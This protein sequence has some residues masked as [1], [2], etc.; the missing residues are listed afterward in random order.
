MD[1]PNAQLRFAWLLVQLGFLLVPLQW[2]VIIP[3]T[4]LTIAR[5]G[6][7]CILAGAALGIVSTRSK[8]TSMSITPQI[9]LALHAFFL[10]FLALSS[11]WS[12]DPNGGL[13]IALRGL[14]YLTLTVVLFAFLKK[15]PT[16]HIVEKLTPAAV[17]ATLLYWIV[18]TIHLQL[19][20]VDV[21]G[22]YQKALLQ[23]SP[24]A[25]QF[26]VFNTLFESNMNEDSESASAG[27]HSV[28]LFLCISL[29]MIA[30]FRSTRTSQGSFFRNGYVVL[31]LLYIIL[32]FSRQAAIACLTVV[33][34]YLGRQRWTKIAVGAVAFIAGCVVFLLAFDDAAELAHQKLVV[35]VAENDRTL[36]ATAVVDGL[37]QSPLFGLGAGTSLSSGVVESDYPHNL[38]LFALHQTGAVGG[39][40]VVIYSVVLI[41]LFL[42]VIRIYFS[43]VGDIRT[44]AACCLGLLAIPIVRHSVGVR[45]ELELSASVAMA[46]ALAI[47]IE[48]RGDRSRDNESFEP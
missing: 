4:P 16:F 18:S 7:A 26:G 27:R 30:A 33:A 20:G 41:L 38:I 23:G 13:F 48:F 47:Y 3:G 31:T 6:L 37:K 34:A 10:V 28:M 11:F 29:A 15:F 22:A 35:D 1:P 45:G 12:E 19:L 9:L 17:L 24:G 2:L 32:S 43:N 8:V 21:V 44:Y 42:D 40:F 5:C 25:V 14:I 46:I 36:H 39:L